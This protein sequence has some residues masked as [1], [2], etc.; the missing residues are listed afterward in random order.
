MVMNEKII[1]ASRPQGL[2]SAEYFTFVK[3]LCLPHKQVKWL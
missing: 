2:P 3:S 1:L